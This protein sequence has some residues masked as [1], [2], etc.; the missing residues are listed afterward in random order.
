M[1]SKDRYAVQAYAKNGNGE[2]TPSRSIACKTA[3]E[4]KSRAERCCSVGSSAG[5]AAFL[6]RGDEDI[7]STDEPIAFAIYGEVPPEVSDRIPF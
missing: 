7:G 5:A 6:L 2:I 1:A 4:A 3:D